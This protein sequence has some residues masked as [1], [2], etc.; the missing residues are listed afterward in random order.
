MDGEADAAR[1]HFLQKTVA[2]D[3]QSLEAELDLEQVPGVDAVVVEPRQLDLLDSGK[4]VEEGLGDRLPLA[5]HLFGPGELVEAEGG[6]D[7]GQVYL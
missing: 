7:V 2:V 4:A 6:G 1:A 3:L 5:P